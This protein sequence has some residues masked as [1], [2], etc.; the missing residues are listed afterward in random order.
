[1]EASA[2]PNAA[3][4]RG[5]WISALR[6]AELWLRDVLCIAE[7]APE[8]GVRGGSEQA[9]RARRRRTRRRRALRDAVE[10]VAETRH[11]PAL[12]VSEELAL[13]ALAYR[14]AGP[15]GALST[16]PRSARGSAPGRR[17]R[18][19]GRREQAVVGAVEVGG[20]GAEQA[21]RCAARGDQLGL[22]ARVGDVEG[23]DAVDA[24]RV[25]AV[26]R[27]EHFVGVGEVPERVRPHGDA[28]GVVDRLDRL[29]DGGRLAQAEGGR[30][31]DQV[32]RGSASRRR[33]CS[34]RAGATALAGR[35]STASARC[36]RPI[37]LP[38]RDA[39]VD[40]RASSSSKPSSRR[41]S[42]MRRVRRSRSARKSARVAGT[43]GSVWS[44]R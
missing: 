16:Q 32:G 5:R 39:R 36:G 30:A 44:I 7:G 42:A 4:A 31:L 33:R 13:E 43:P 9:A 11:A 38:G 6:L 28:A 40:A 12:N 26:D 25:E 19:R 35:A 41:A 29:G 1:M 10:L 23:L 3:R 2:G 27:R 18:R 34:P 15:P 24:E 37:G 14:L 17:C 21:E 22:L 20:A 8:R